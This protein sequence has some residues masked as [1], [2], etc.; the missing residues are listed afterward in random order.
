MSSLR[1]T[2]LLV[3]VSALA[4]LTLGVGLPQAPSPTAAPAYASTAPGGGSWTHAG[5]WTGPASGG[6]CVDVF[7]DG[8]GDYWICGECN[9]TKNPGPG[10]CTKVTADQLQLG[11]WCA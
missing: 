9:T 5:C 6:K 8:S 10:K 1:F 4:L 7:R 2:S 11:R 3:C